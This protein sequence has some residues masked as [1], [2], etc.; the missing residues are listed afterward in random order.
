VVPADLFSGNSLA[1]DFSYAFSQCTS[2]KQAETGLLSGT[3]VSDA[4][5]LF[6]RCVSL[7]SI[8]EAI[9]SPDFFSTVTDVRSAFEGCVKLRGHGLSFISRLPEQVIHARTL[10]QCTALDDYGELPTG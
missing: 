1:T 6:D 8:V 2:L 4:G 7:E 9:F 10:F 3:A 5:H